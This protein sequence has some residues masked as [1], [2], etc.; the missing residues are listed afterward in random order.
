MLTITVTS[1]QKSDELTLCI[2]LCRNVPILYRQELASLIQV[3]EKLRACEIQN[4]VFQ[5][6]ISFLIRVL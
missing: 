5:V 3:Q 6:N 4:K 2:K 1:N